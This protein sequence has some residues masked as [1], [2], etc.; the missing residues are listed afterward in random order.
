MT[1]DEARAQME[2]ATA[3]RQAEREANEAILQSSLDAGDRII[4]R[5]AADAVLTIAP[6]IAAD[7]T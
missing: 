7:P 1:Q 5:K 6:A 4:M 3:S 2:M